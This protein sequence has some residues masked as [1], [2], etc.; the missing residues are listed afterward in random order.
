VRRV[1][2]GEPKFLLLANSPLLILILPPAFRWN[3]TI[4]ADLVGSVDAVIVETRYRYC[5][6]SP[7]FDVELKNLSFPILLP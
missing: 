2:Q 3:F 6:K 5:W 4:F 7:R 1:L